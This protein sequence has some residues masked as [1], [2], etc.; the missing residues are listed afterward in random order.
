MKVSTDVLSSIHLVCIVDVIFELHHIRYL[1]YVQQLSSPANRVSD[2]VLTNRQLV[3]AK[4]DN[5]YK[6][7]S[8]DNIDESL[9]LNL[10]AR[11]AG[12][13]FNICPAGPCCTEES[14]FFVEA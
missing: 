7:R 1:Q 13:A 3:A 10:Y 11:V 4:Q 2:V 6:T 8:T 9:S 12:T 5:G 14:G